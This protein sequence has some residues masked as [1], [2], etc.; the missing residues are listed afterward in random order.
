M[1]RGLLVVVVALGLAGCAEGVEDGVPGQ[2]GP[3]PAAQRPQQALVTDPPGDVLDNE[4]RARET[5]GAPDLVPT[6]DRES[7]PKFPVPKADDED[8]ER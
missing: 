2:P 5:F 7:V 6:I 8:A 3:R 4:P 1:M